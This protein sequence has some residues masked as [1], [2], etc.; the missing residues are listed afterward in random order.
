MILSIENNLDLW[1][2][3]DYAPAN[4][5]VLL[6]HKKRFLQTKS[7]EIP[8]KLRV[9]FVFYSLTSLTFLPG[10]AVFLKTISPLEIAPTGQTCP[11]NKQPTHLS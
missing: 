11:H 3:E 4:H 10:L 7:Q 6:K 8:G 2:P 1:T 9:F 5:L